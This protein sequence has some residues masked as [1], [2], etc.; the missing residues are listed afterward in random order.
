MDRTV[1][2]SNQMIRSL[3]L[4]KLFP[5]IFYF[6]IFYI[7]QTLFRCTLIV[8]LFILYNITLHSASKKV[9][10]FQDGTLRLFHFLVASLEKNK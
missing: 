3:S 7:L 4:L 5:F 2:V 10:H 1:F 6:F 8:R 9:K